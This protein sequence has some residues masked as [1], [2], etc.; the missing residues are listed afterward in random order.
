MTGAQNFQNHF[1]LYIQ[2][3]PYVLYTHKLYTDGL[4]SNMPTVLTS[5]IR[6]KLSRPNVNL[7]PRK[8][9]NGFSSHRFTVAA[10][11]QPPFMMK[12]VTT[13]IAGNKK[14]DWDGYE[15]RLLKLMSEHLNFSYQVLEPL[16]ENDLGYV[17]K[18]RRRS[19]AFLSN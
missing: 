7:F 11:D 3:R 19:L 12:T 15:L 2:E 8:F 18:Q 9:H 10:I 4:G 16:E 17:F 6:T 5:W 1:F 13:D 14:V